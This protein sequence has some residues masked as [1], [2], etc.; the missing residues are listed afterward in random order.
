[1][2]ASANHR[3]KYL[4]IAGQRFGQLTVQS[5]SNSSLAGHAY[6]HCVCDCGNKA[7]VASNRLRSGYIVSCYECK[8]AGKREPKK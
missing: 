8:K 2:G 7:V 3:P 5:F 1:M 6:W 4:N